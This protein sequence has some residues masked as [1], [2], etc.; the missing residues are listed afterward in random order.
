M[1]R[2][3]VLLGI[4]TLVLLTAS[5]PVFGAGT[6]SGAQ[7][8]GVRQLMKQA[9]AYPGEIRVQGVVSRVFPEQHMLALIDAEE[10]KE[11][12]VVTCA[13]LTLPVQWKGAMP[14][15]TDTVLA[16]GEVRKKGMR[17]LFVAE[18]LEKV[19]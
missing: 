17:K 10:F 13:Q 5:A 15:V 18:S 6:G 8:V 3:G 9:D 14:K 1:K 19:N 7:T 4:A 11:C 2:K 16:E 12:K